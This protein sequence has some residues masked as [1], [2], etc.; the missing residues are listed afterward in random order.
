MIKK[1][2]ARLNHEKRTKKTIKDALDYQI[3]TMILSYKCDIIC[4]ALKAVLNPVA[5]RYRGNNNARFTAAH[6]NYLQTI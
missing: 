6:K 5:W 4:T 3:Q 2:R 1:P